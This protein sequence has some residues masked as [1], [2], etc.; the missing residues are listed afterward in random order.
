VYIHWLFPL[1]FVLDIANA[2][3]Y[4]EPFLFLALFMCLVDLRQKWN[5]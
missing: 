5:Y 2:F 3:R 4:P 1:I